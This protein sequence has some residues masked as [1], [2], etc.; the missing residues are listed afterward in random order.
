MKL[1]TRGRCNVKYTND[2]F[3]FVAKPNLH[4]IIS[5]QLAACV[6]ASIQTLIPTHPQVSLHSRLG[7]LYYLFPLFFQIRSAVGSYKVINYKLK[8][9]QMKK[10]NRKK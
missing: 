5:S 1:S 9:Q 2:I 10:R 4:R 7:V 3:F 6:K 8:E